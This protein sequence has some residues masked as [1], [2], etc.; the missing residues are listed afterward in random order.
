MNNK[1]S[2]LIE[3]I[4][5]L[6]HQKQIRSH[7]ELAY[8]LDERGFANVS[9]SQISRLLKQVGAVYL[10]N[11]TGESVYA[12]KHELMIPTLDTEIHEL[13]VAI[14]TNENMIMVSTV[15]GAANIVAG[16]ID[17][18]KDKLQ[19]LAVIAGDDSVMVLPVA[20]KERESISL[21]LQNLFDE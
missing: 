16:I 14:N 2:P 20:I 18:M 7:Y 9:Q 19:V 15:P 21:N 11:A 1:Q 5:E 3:N 6:L 8:Y 17:N 13:V 4:K 12:I 10:K